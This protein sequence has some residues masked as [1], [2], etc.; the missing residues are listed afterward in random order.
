MYIEKV[1]LEHFRNFKKS[2][3]KFKEKTLVIGPND[4]GKT[5]LIHALRILLDKSLSTADIEPS[6]TDFNVESKSNEL[7]IFIHFADVVED[8]VVSTFKGLVS[9]D[10]KLVL[11]YYAYRDESGR[12]EYEIKAG[13]SITSLQDQKNRHYLRSLNLEYVKSSRDLMNYLKREKKKIFESYKEERTDEERE[14]D[15]EVIQKIQ[16]SLDNINKKVKDLSFIKRTL[17]QINSEL[18]TLTPDDDDV[19]LGFDSGALDPDDY[20]NNVSLI[21]E[22]NGERIDIGGDGRN[23]QIFL[24]MWSSRKK[25]SDL[26]EVTIFCVEE[27]EAHLHPHNQRNLAYYLYKRLRGQVIITTHSP[28]IA[29]EFSPNSIIK[30]Y[31]YSKNT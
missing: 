19:I 29:C 21:S 15:S 3:I 20:V 25:R 28:Q 24:S 17:K 30:L 13:R 12:K 6:D 7:K 10:G 27:P 26:E 22:S 11:A 4:I 1:R 2:V 14:K 18:Q 16:K 5:N 31:K 23:N 8:C 9:D